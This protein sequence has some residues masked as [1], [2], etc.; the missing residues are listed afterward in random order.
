MSP[1]T[2]Y[3][4]ALPW[5]L[6]ECVH[7][8]AAAQPCKLSSDTWVSDVVH[9]GAPILVRALPDDL[10]CAVLDHLEL[11]GALTQTERCNAD[12]AHY[13]WLPGSAIPWH[14]DGKYV[15]AVTVYTNQRWDKNWGGYMAYLDGLDVKCIAP[16]FNT[17]ASIITP[18]EHTVFMVHPSAPPRTTL[19]IFVH[20]M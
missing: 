3:Q 16:S 10:K 19:Q 20:R 11:R 6:L 18:V 1:V 17:A 4:N 2:I 15:K 8:S 13:T 9:A 14:A 12:A 7:A 5:T